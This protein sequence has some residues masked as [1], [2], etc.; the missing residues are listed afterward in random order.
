MA[1][2]AR[3]NLDGSIAEKW[4]IL[5]KA[6]VFGRGEQVDVRLRD[7]R[8]SRQHFA[9]ALKDGAYHLQDLKS[10]NGTYVN[11]ARITEVVLKPSDRI[12]AGQT[13]LIFETAQSKGLST[14]IGELA[15]EKKG[16]D[17]LLGEI[18][19]EAQTPPA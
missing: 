12:R 5:D 7:D 19:R 16:Y 17:T 15:A 14:V 3:K 8:A 10:T 18:S 13:V 6:L 2:I 9:V 4:E 1:Y 11:G